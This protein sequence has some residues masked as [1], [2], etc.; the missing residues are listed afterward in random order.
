VPPGRGSEQ[1]LTAG[2]CNGTA[3]GVSWRKYLRLREARGRGGSK[4]GAGGGGGSGPPLS[5][6]PA[7]QP[8]REEMGRRRSVCCF[9]WGR[10]EGKG[11]GRLD[12]GGGGSRKQGRVM[13]KRTR[14][15]AESESTLSLAVCGTCIWN[16]MEW[17]TILVIILSYLP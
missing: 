6:P 5:P 11:G 17:N 3:V 16:R 9:L 7:P 1:E 14:N 13:G 2:D 12:G 4:R 8:N 15:I 10:P